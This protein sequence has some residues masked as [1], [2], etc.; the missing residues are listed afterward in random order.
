MPGDPPSFVADFTLHLL[1]MLNYDDHDRLIRWNVPTPL[2]MRGRDIHRG[3]YLRSG[4][5]RCHRSP[6]AGG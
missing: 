3:G 4:P 2:L 5:G 1:G 6:C